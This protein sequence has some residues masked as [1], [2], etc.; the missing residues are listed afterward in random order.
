MLGENSKA[1]MHIL[2]IRIALSYAYLLSGCQCILRFKSIKKRKIL[3]FR[4]DIYANSRSV[5]FDGEYDT[6]IEN[7]R[8]RNE[9]Q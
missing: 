5:N 6:P 4:L 3:R 2:S 1:K 8:Q 7:F 9:I